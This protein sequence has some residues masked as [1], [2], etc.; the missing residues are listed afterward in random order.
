MNRIENKAIRNIAII[1]HVDHGKTTLVDSMF[2]QSGIFREGQQID[3]RLMDS[4]DL[5]RERGITIAAKNCAVGWKGVKINIIDT[6]GHSDFGGEVERAL[7]MA[8]GAILLVDASEGPLPQ[9]RFVLDKALQGGLKII[10]VINKIDRQDARPLAVLDEV[11]SLLIDLDA[12]DDQLDFPVLY[13]IGRDGIATE[14][15]DTP[16]ENIHILLDKIVEELPGPRYKKDEPFQMLVSDLSYSDYLGRLAIGKVVNG[17]IN[18]GESLVC[19]N[20]QGKSFPLKVSKLQAYSGMGLKEVSAVGPG[21]IVVLSGIEEV[22]I[23]DTICSKDNPKALPRI[24]V[25]EPT[26]FMKFYRN[27]SPYAGLDGKFVQS[28][29]IEE[30]LKKETLLNVSMQFENTDD[31]EGWIVKGRGELQMAILIETMRREGF[32]LAVGRPQVIFKTEN[33]KKLEPM[34]HVYIDCADGFSGIVTEKLSRRK[35]KLVN[36]THGETSRVRLE[37]KAPA[38]ALIGY[39]D[40]FL[41]DTR[42]TGLLNTSFAGYEEYKGDFARRFSGS[43]I[44]DR[45]GTAVPYALFNLEP[46]GILFIKPGEKV[47]EGMIIGEHNRDNDLN[48]NPTKTKKL[49]NMRAS[50][51]DE[52]VILT[53]ILPMTLERAIQ[54]IKDDEIVEIT[55]KILRIRKIFLSAQERKRRENY[56]RSQIHT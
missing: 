15:L 21:E 53:P 28:S 12:N 50:G 37:F 44:S 9:T 38:R 35:G 49:S 3:D 6:P 24:T 41:T 31:G 47:Y 18:S 10:V 14:S 32:E 48:V 4:M 40:E 13:A 7:S 27:T 1:A 26:V 45:S 17:N 43:L 56:E 33:G 16:G 39:R 25:D 20:K 52:A 34:E 5:E 11:Y 46:R 54:F 30:R 36:M 8:D 51:K 55:P 23:G 2:K 29:K 22:H 19:I 42:G